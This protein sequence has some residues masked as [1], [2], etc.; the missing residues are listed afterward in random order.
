M[1]YR[2]LYTSAAMAGEEYNIS[3]KGLRITPDRIDIQVMPGGTEEGQFPRLHGWVHDGG[4][5]G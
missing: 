1:G 3:D 2:E 5:R 4:C